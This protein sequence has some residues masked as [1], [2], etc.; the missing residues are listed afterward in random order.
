MTSH[1]M[2]CIVKGSFESV[3]GAMC[4]AFGDIHAR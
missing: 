2:R 1:Y 3:F 4:V